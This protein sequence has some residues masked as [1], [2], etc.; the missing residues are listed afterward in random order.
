MGAGE[1]TDRLLKAEQAVTAA[2]GTVVR[3]SGVETER[4]G[5]AAPLLH[6]EQ[7]GR[8]VFLVLTWW[9]GLLGS[10][11]AAGLYTRDRGAHT[12]FLKV[13][14]VK[15]RPDGLV[16]MLQSDA[17]AA[18]LSPPLPAAIC[19]CWPTHMC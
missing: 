11:F 18:L 8:A 19:L 9:V 13:P 14:E 17:T 6:T 2:G 10:A 5:V 16:S 1:R 12:F 7:R 4:A 3:L 15:S